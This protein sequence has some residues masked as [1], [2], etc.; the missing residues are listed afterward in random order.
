MERSKIDLLLKQVVESLAARARTRNL[1]GGN[2]GSRGGSR[3]RGIFFD[4]GAKFVKSAIV[5][6]VLAGDTFQDRLH[7]FKSRG[8]IKVG[9][10]LA[11]VQL[12]SALR[13][14][15]FGIETRLQNSAAI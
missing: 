10:L 7:A 3:R 9:A 12:E 5:P 2:R 13:A 6:L 4:R 8:R 14:F 15:A 1:L 11:G